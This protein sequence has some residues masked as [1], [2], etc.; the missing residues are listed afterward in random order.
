M[1]VVSSEIGHGREGYGRADTEPALKRRVEFCQ[2]ARAGIPDLGHVIGQ[3]MAVG[4]GMVS[5]ES[6]KEVSSSGI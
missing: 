2:V 1:Y 5:M 4:N 3:T 6:C